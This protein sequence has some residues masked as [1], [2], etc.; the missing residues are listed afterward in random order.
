MRLLSTVL[1]LAALS[2]AIGCGST[3]IQD[4]EG[5]E[6]GGGECC[7]MAPTCPDG[8]SQVD[9]CKTADCFEVKACCSTVKCEPAATCTE[10]PVCEIYETKVDS[11]P[12]GWECREV[13][14]CGTTILCAQEVFCDGYPSCDPGDVEVSTCPLDASCYTAEA[15][16]TTIVCLDAALPQHGCPL[17]EPQEGDPCPEQMAICD[18]DIGNNCF[19]SHLC[20]VN[21]WT[22]IGGGCGVDN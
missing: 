22:A 8:S 6:G 19:A 11:C 21:G 1:G 9:S 2:G 12:G 18:Y 10:V 15:C 17:V 5:G 13:S 7:L 3:V 20:D 16:G 4:G 14:A